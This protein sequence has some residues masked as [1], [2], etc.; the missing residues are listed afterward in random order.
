MAS[1]CDDPK[2][3]RRILF[4]DKA[5]KRKCI[6]LGKMPKRLAD[7][8][9]TKVESLNAAAISGHSIDGETADWLRRIGDK[10]HERLARVGLVPSRVPA[11]PE[12]QIRLAEW[13]DTYIAGRTDVKLTTRHN[14]EVCR[15]RLVE[16]FGVDTALAKITPGDVDA[17]VIRL[18]ERYAEATIGRRVRLAKQL[19]RAAIRKRL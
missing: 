8:T 7:E 19:F 10:L 16:F 2:G 5:G 13:L 14:L 17:W 1:I 12:K 9:K 11:E 4:V 15:D 3:F 18:R 6:R